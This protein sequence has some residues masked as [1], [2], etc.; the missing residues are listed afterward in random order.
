[1]STPADSGA[2]IRAARRAAGLT[3]R[4]LAARIGVSAATM[5]AVEN[6]RTGVSVTRLR[7]IAAALSVPAAALLAGST[8]PAEPA[9]P[10]REVA[11]WRVFPALD[12]DPV[13]DA[14]VAAIVE[15]GYHGTTM[16]DVARRANMSVPG[17]YH[18]YQDKQ[19]LL[20]RILDVTMDELHGRIAAARAEAG[21]GVEQVAVIVEALALFH[22]HRRAL[23][24]IG[25]SEMRSLTE[26]NRRR[27]AESRN[28]VQRTLDDAIDR[29][30]AEGALRG[31]APG[32]AQL[33]T[34][35]RAI[36]TMCTS[37]P[38]WFRPDGPATPE[39]I[40]GDY[41]D[42]ALAL[43]GGEPRGGTPASAQR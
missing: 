3:A 34:A 7:E 40:A 1:M 43:L 25:A 11:Q 17:I 21:T 42:F 9:Q 35:G 32:S 30:A 19:Q 20:V 18:H 23:A 37:L 10:V 28:R 22:T 29:A 6:G 31:A 2:P 13:L 41:A 8:A 4:E 14:A 5:S 27:I 36:A 38:Q 39:Q 16:R 26:D 33:R 15:T 24:F 12:M